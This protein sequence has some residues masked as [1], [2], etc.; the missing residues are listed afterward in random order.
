MNRE[1]F[2]KR[3]ARRKQAAAGGLPG[4]THATEAGPMEPEPVEADVPP[5]LPPLETLD[6]DSDFSGFMH[7]K[8]DP[9]IRN[10]ALKKLFAGPHYRVSDGLDVYVGDY[11][12]P[13]ELPAAMLAGL[14]HARTLLAAANPETAQ[15]GL[16]ASAPEHAA[17]PGRVEPDRAEPDHAV[18]P[19][20][21]LTA[22]VAVA[23]T[24]SPEIVPPSPDKPA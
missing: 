15:A 24:A 1:S 23:G 9:E 14:A 20:Q 12:A 19:D 21:S 17:T 2:L 3:W 11:S 4:E 8:V 10:A 18:A 13:A 22:G 16:S 7:S 5:Q 6:A